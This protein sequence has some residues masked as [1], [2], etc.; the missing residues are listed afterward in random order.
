MDYCFAF[1]WVQAANHSMLTQVRCKSSK[2]L[3][4]ES[5][6]KGS[7]ELHEHAKTA[8]LQK[9]TISLKK[10]YFLLFLSF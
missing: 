2:I 3:D 4:K 1:Q 6:A 7:Y 5:T 10:L 9:Q 8:A